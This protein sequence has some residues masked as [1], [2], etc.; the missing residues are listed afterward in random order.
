MILRS[1]TSDGGFAHVEEIGEGGTFVAFE[2]AYRRNGE[3]QQPILS[4]PV[5]NAGEQVPLQIVDHE[6]QIPRSSGEIVSSEVGVNQFDPGVGLGGSFACDFDRDLRC[7]DH[8][9]LPSALCEPDRM[10]AGTACKVKGPAGS[11][12][13]RRKLD[14]DERGRFHR[15]RALPVPVVPRSAG[16]ARHLGGEAVELT[17]DLGHLLDFEVSSDA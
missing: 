3:G 7:I 2:V 9:D 15:C 1:S 10:T 14:A 8:R 11:V 6:D 4:H 13:E 17:E 5:D 16:H 12:E